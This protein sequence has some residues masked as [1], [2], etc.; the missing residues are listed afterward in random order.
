MNVLMIGVDKKS[1]GGMLTVAENYMNDDEF[2]KRT[3]LIYIPTVTNSNI[4]F[5]ILFFI[6]AFIKII[7]VIKVKK[8]EIVHINM[9]E[10]GSVFREGL[11][12]LISKALG[13]KTIIHMHGA[14]IEEWYKR[15]KRSV[16]K[17]VYKI[18][19]NADRI[20]VLGYIWKE[21]MDGLVEDKSKVLVV[22]NAVSVPKNNKYNINAN[23]ITFLG[24]LS[25]RK[26]IDDLLKAVKKIK[27]R[28]PKYIK[29]KLY[30][31]DIDG[32][33]NK[34]IEEL[35]LN[36]TV[37]YC[38]WVT[39]DKQEECFSNTLVNILPSYNE[40]LPMS[41]LE[42][43]AY[44]IPNISTNIAAIPEAISNGE[45]GILVEPGDIG[46]I[47]SGILK[48][49]F[50]KE[51]RKKYSENSYDRIKKEFNICKHMESIYKIYLDLMN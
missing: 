14:T 43:M 22:Y 12:L 34:K 36:D 28:L 3:N 21:F 20:L 44:G 4:L 46:A 24:V 11:V 26:G 2:K 1:L 42:T 50:D 19:N 9:A 37:E 40:G 17:F 30:G 35:Q 39:K 23:N 41:I 27:D 29:V 6:K 15:Q 31:V 38:G 49:V 51:I 25:Q 18:F 5:K 7:L 33:I 13:C 32:R 16:K 47:S 8:I 48:M 10:K 45:E